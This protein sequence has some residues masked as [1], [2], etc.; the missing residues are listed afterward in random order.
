MTGIEKYLRD[1]KPD[2]PDEGQFLIETNAR[3][4]KVEGIKQCVEE[5]R[6]RGRTALVVALAGGFLLGCF[7]TL[8]VLL[9][10]IPPI[11]VDSGSF[12]RIVAKLSEW[13][14]AFIGMIAV[15]AIALGVVF[16]TRKKEAL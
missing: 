13:R 1:N 3:L 14:D 6:R 16:M 2:I 7:V 8:L 12:G 5:E 15:C 4:S 11:D 9:Y 10:P